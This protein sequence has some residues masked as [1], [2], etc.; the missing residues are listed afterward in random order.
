[1]QRVLTHHAM[2]GSMGQVAS[3][4]DNAAMESF[5]SLPHKDVLNRQRWPTRNELRIVT[6]TWI[7]LTYHRRGRQAALD[8]LTPAEFEII[9]TA[10][11]T[12]AACRRVT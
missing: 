2:V 8:R 10:Q 3:A 12:Q 5:F 4:A 1:M 9:E 6:V 11:A 7:E